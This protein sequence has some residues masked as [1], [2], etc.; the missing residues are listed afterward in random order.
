MQPGESILTLSS[1]EQE[2][3]LKDVLRET[4]A[5]K[6]R[7]DARRRKQ[8]QRARDHAAKAEAKQARA[9]LEREYPEL[10]EIILTEE[11]PW[12]AERYSRD[13][14]ELADELI[15]EALRDFREWESEHPKSDN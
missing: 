3:R 6:K 2:Q 15:I 7:R 14:R 12:K 13:P 4:E 5:E 9:T 1:T 8:L 11:V 10:L